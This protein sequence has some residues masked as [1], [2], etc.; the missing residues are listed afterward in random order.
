MAKN[1]CDVSMMS[2][3]FLTGG[4]G[5]NFERHVAA[6]FVLSMVIDG[7]SPIV[8]SPITAVKF[9]AK[10]LNYDVDDLVVTSVQG[11]K[12]QRLL[13]QVKH[14]VIITAK[15]PIFQEVI[16]A[17]W[18]DFSKSSFNRKTDMI[19]LVTGFI[20]KNSISA[21]RFLNDQ[22]MA[23]ISAEEFT[24]RIN[25][26]TFTSKIHYEKYN[27]IKECIKKA[28]GNKSATEEDL[29]MFCRCFVLVVF[30]LDYEKSVNQALIHSLIKCNTEKDAKLVWSRIAD[31]CGYWKQS[32]ATVTKQ[33]V[34]EDI[35]DLFGA[36]RSAKTIDHIPA[37][38][39]PSD[40]WAVAALIGS[41]NEKNANDIQAIEQLT[42]NNYTLFQSECRKHLDTGLISLTNSQW[43][44]NNRHAVMDAAWNYYFDDAIKS[45]YQI[46]NAY[47]KEVSKQ[48]DSNGAYSII[49]PASG[50][51][52]HSEEFRKGLLEG[53]CILANGS[54]PA[55]CS[56]HLI[57]S[58]SIQMVRSVLTDC[59]WT[60]LVS[61]NDL[62]LLLGEISPR[63]YLDSLEQLICSKPHEIEFLFP[64]KHASF[65]DH[66]FITNIL[67]SLEQL[68]WHEDYLVK[69]VACL[70]A[71]EALNYEETN[72]V[73]T[74]MNSMLNILNP[75]RPQTSAPL[76]KFKSAIQTIDVDY[77]DIC[78]EVCCNVLS[79]KCLHGLSDNMLP[80][81]LQSKGVFQ[82]GLTGEDQRE[83]LNYYIQQALAMVGTEKDRMQKLFENLSMQQAKE[84]TELYDRIRS[85]ASSW[86]EEEKAELWSKLT[87]WKYRLILHNDS[88]EPETPEFIELCNT[89]GVVQPES[90]L[91]RYKRLFKFHYDE[92]SGEEN[93][94]RKKEQR[95]QE[96]VAEIYQKH[97]I[98]ALLE[99]GESINAA[100]DIGYRLGQQIDP[101]EMAQIVPMCKSGEH[102]TFFMN[103][104]SAFFKT[105]GM[106]A[107]EQI[108]IPADDLELISFV[109]KH[110]PFSQE[111][112]DLVSVHLLGHEEM[113]WG[114][115]RI[116][117]Y[118]NRHSDYDAIKVAQILVQYQRTPA[119]IALLADSVDELKPDP[120]MVCNMLIQA[121][122]EQETEK[123]DPESTR[124]LIKYLQDSG[125]I[126]MGVLGEIE[127]CYLIWLDEHSDVCP[128]AIEYRLANEPDSFCDLM[129]VLYKKRHD[130]ATTR[131]IPQAIS[132]RLFQLTYQYSVI[133]GMDWDGNFHSD[134]FNSW[135][136]AVKVWA[137][138]NDRYEVSMHTIGGAL[139]YVE[140]DE[141]GIINT[142]VMTELNK[143][144]NDELRK[145]YRLGTFN[146]RG[147]HWVDPEGK[148]EKE[149][150][151]R[152]QYRANAV[153]ALGYIR[154]AELLRSIAD[155]Y[156]A[157]AQDNIREFGEVED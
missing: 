125:A 31:K 36:T 141:D 148:P 26:P 140:F 111:L 81:H 5:E 64:K 110:A 153:E 18:K 116:L 108:D 66:N 103:L 126:A 149:L 137:K 49:I 144:D 24:D 25:Q 47:L 9:Q 119:A 131:T 118:Y 89:I 82:P 51:F 123:I 134:V 58:E 44:V 90:I 45:A 30:D 132:K 63:T 76:V 115:V 40:F 34:P 154:F 4:G 27:I 133:P 78:W 35:L 112:M 100:Y 83:L 67:F 54:K 113:F 147:V 8:E 13:C 60:R 109:L 127:F 23:S 117:P 15:N 135:M 156:L 77:H 105:N 29:W 94:W 56:D 107:F 101:N 19:A 73:N 129:S 143:I 71:L 11:D 39:S 22:A 92:L 53:L 93:R 50:R 14:S 139:S 68:A 43:K 10:N 95:K 20:A 72:W 57:E 97:G 145:G 87:D 16:T 106:Q 150:A 69:S 151:Q 91:L 33:S 99:F 79:R 1:E 80:K 84:L 21:M 85:A 32:A 37:S 55:H 146:Q 74:P 41:W 42:R 155:G 122:K 96:A 130:E 62:I 124:A 114:S 17:A 98:Q 102:S 38:F 104:V 61:L 75:Y 46:A 88:K 142:A 3:A 157:E 86:K 120:E 121:P 65:M 48:F 70:S 128:R 152:Y 12:E 28:N 138:E 136:E 52:S 6:V 7:F 59:D 2:P